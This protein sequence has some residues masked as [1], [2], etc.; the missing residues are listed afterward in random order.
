MKEKCV[1]IKNVIALT[2]T[3]REAVICEAD[4][5]TFLHAA[6]TR[7]TQRSLES[8]CPMVVSILDARIPPGGR[9]R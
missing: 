5:I 1:A 9:T 3:L 6:S 2:M 7:V 4:E 8:C